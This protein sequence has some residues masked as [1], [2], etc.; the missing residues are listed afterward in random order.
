MRAMALRDLGAVAAMR[1]EHQR[2]LRLAGASRGIED[3]VGAQA[4]DELVNILD[5]VDLARQ[6]GV[7]EVD[8]DRLVSEGRSLSTDAA[9]ELASGGRSS[10]LAMS[11]PADDRA[12]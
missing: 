7:P 4:P 10:V 5:P 12:P 1:G 2:G 9:L 11:A 3:S 6:A 8:I